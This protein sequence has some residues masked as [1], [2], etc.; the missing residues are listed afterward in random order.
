MNK[1]IKIKKYP[2]RRLYNTASGSYITLEDLANL[3]KTNHNIIV[4]DAKSGHDITK[5]ILIQI[6]LELQNKGHDL[7]PLSLL[8]QII[9][10]HNHHFGKV[11]SEYL[12]LSIDFLSKNDI[13]VQNLLDAMRNN[14]SITPTVWWKNGLAAFNHQ[15]MHFMSMLLTAINRC[16]H[17]G[18]EQWHTHKTSAKL[19][20][21]D[22]KG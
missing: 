3:I 21:D 15:N 5:A 9:K 11:L 8:K 1:I 14:V 19:N 4:T 6:V 12:T 10:A 22:K 2:N 13:Y 7:L 20:D 18:T 16:Y 17:L